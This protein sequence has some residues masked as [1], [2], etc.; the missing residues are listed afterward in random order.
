MTT[1]M[2][3]VS[4]C[5]SGSTASGAR[6]E[7]AF[8][9]RP[10]GRARRTRSAV[11][12]PSS[13]T[14]TNFASSRRT[15]RTCRLRSRRSPRDSARRRGRRAKPPSKV[16]NV[17]PGPAGPPALPPVRLAARIL[18]IIAFVSDPCSDSM[19]AIFGKVAANE[20]FLES[21]AKT[22][23]TIAST[24][25]SAARRPMRRFAKSKT[26][27]SWSGRDCAKG[28]P[29]SLRRPAIGQNVGAHERD[30]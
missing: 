23:V 11:I 18:A 16:L 3:A 20:S 12:S 4:I 26:V 25:T 24:S 15:L 28:S 2:G 9:A 13:A 22:P 17:P 8:A 19:A 29:R 10:A 5:D 6:P 21:P 14:N 1:A 7:S 30:G 27:S